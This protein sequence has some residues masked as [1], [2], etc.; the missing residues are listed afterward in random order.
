MININQERVTPPYIS[1]LLPNEIFVFGSNFEGRHGKGAAKQALVFGAKYGSGVGMY[2][3]TYAIPTRYF[4]SG[5][6]HSS[7][8]TSFFDGDSSLITIPL[9]DISL[10][11]NEFIEFCKVNTSLKFLV[12][13][14]GCN[15]A[16]YIPKDIAPMFE[17]SKDL[18][19]VYLPESF[20]D[21]LS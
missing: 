4:T 3:N 11:V 12:T 21:V 8:G 20:W 5:K 7:I 18:E 15:N 14:I 9:Y 13:E 2:G 10:Y 19:N 6:V 16:G 1:S 17:R